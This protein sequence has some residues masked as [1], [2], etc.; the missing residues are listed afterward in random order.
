MAQTS[1]GPCK[2]IRDIGSSSYWWFIIAPGQEANG[3]NF[4]S[5]IQ[6]GDS[7]DT[8]NIQYYINKKIS[9]NICFLELSEKFR[10]DLKQVWIIQGNRVFDVRVIKVLLSVG[11][12]LVLLDCNLSLKPHAAQH[13]TCT[14]KNVYSTHNHQHNYWNIRIK[15]NTLVQKRTHSDVL[16][17]CA[18][19]AHTK[20]HE[21]VGHL[22]GTNVALVRA[23]QKS[24]TYSALPLGFVAMAAERSHRLIM[25]KWLNRI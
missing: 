7:Y 5:S 11:I 20:T 10:T 12:K 23:I 13:Y 15:T 6:W 2:F 8:H 18:Y 22:F 17:K 1:F 14:Y 19:V 24:Q 25:R 4:W 3:D 21:A 16:C 9:L